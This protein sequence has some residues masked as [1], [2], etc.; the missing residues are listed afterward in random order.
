MIDPRRL[1]PLLPT[2]SAVVAALEQAGDELLYNP[3][4]EPD[5]HPDAHAGAREAAVLVPLRFDAGDILLT[6]RPVHLRFGGA[7]VFP[8]GNR[9][10][11]DADPIA[12]ALRECEEEIGIGSDALD[13]LGSLPDY[14]THAGYRI[15]PVVAAL[16]SALRPQPNPEEVAAVFGVPFA[17]LFSPRHYVLRT[18][19]RAPWRANFVLYHDDVPISGPTISIILH[20]YRLLAAV[21]A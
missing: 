11:A 8:G 15:T 2:R 4:H 9:D 14:Y 21:V 3:H 6:R 7:V 16:S 12:T 18:R 17:R 19:S 1:P 10:P 13:V 5:V 20:L